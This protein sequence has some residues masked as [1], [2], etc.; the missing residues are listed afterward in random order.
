MQVE[1]RR[2]SV[3]KMGSR[4]STQEAKPRRNIHASG[5]SLLQEIDVNAI[6][7]HVVEIATINSGIAPY[8]TISWILYHIR[9]SS[10]VFMARLGCVQP[11]ASLGK[12][13]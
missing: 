3:R 5:P 4:K 12:V 8:Q 7:N 13:K 9:H 2:R 10:T 11:L 1:K 6:L